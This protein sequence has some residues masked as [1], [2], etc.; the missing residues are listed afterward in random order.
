MTSS[1]KP[2]RQSSNRDNRPTATDELLDQLIDKLG[3]D[4]QPLSPQDG[5]DRYLK[6]KRLSITETTLDEYAGKLDRFREFLN[7]RNI[8]DLRELDGRLLDEYVTWL[9]YESSDQVEELAPKTMRDE[10]YLLRDLIGYLEDIDAIAPGLS[11]KIDIPDLPNNAGIRNVDLDPERVTRI[12]GYLEQY[13]YASLDHVVWVLVARIARRT[14]AFVGIDVPDAH[15][16]LAQ[17]Y[18]ELKH[19]PPSTPLKNGVDG[20]GQ[21]A[22]TKQDAEILS[23]YIENVRPDVRVDSGRRPLLASKHG[24][25][26][27]S[28]FRRRIYKWSRPCM[29]SR[30]C[31]HDRDPDECKAME[32]LDKAAKCPSSRSPHAIRH[33]Y[34]SEGRRRGVPIEVLSDRCDVSP[35][36]IR[37]VYDESTQEER[38]EARRRILDEYASE[39][40]GGYL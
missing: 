35:E 19:R 36:V 27:K 13:H 34:L 24:R 29:I 9:K 6:R 21:V 37:Q 11:D 33:G 40:G 7:R 22:L 3:P 30:S 15:L 2:N 32:Q 28:T 39:Q 1:S 18:I 17:P 31:P 25:I 23:K 14:G 4:L 12:L 20:E 26:A 5:I 10:S 16:D 8:D 38:R